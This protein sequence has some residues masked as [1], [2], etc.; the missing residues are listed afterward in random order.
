MGKK[1]SGKSYKGL[2]I[3]L[4]KKTPKNMDCY[5]CHQLFNTGV[6]SSILSYNN[7][8]LRFFLLYMEILIFQTALVSWQNAATRWQQ[9]TA[10]TR[11]LLLW[12]RTDLQSEYITSRQQA[13]VTKTDPGPGEDIK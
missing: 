6:C 5:C 10:N 13:E 2:T 12:R 7:I 9:I 1:D 8:Y 11:V 3:F 4:F